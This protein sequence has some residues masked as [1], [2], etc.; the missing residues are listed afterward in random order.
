[1]AADAEDLRALEV[2][3]SRV[4]DRLNGMPLTRAESASEAC[5][6]TAGLIVERTR[7]MTPAIPAGAALPRLAPHALGALIA[8]VGRD[9][10]D[11]ARASSDAD[12]GPVLNALV[13][14]RRAL[15]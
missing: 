6:D 1:M 11:A 3:L 4:A 2:E 12:V 10:L 8:V 13:E 5:Y 15:P 9:Y 7:T 14:L